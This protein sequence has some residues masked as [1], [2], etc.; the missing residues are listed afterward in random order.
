MID[1][2]AFQK[3]EINV[4][5]NLGHHYNQMYKTICYILKVGIGDMQPI[6]RVIT[7]FTTNTISYPKRF[8]IMQL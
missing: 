3:Q 1:I 5:D 8:T 7:S 4:E 6:Y 2:E